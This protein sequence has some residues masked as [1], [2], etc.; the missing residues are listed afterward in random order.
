MFMLLAPIASWR[1]A[2]ALFCVCLSAAA[3]TGLRGG[4]RQLPVVEGQDIKFTRLSV[5]GESLQSKVASITQDGYGFLWFGTDDG[6]YRYDGYNLKPYRRERDNP[7]SLSDD[8][9]TALYRDRAGILWVGTGYGGLNRLDPASDTF[10]HYRHDPANRASLSDN[11]VRCIL[12]DS[13]GTLW[14][15]TNLGLDRLDPASGT[16]VHHIHNPKDPGS[17]SN[18]LV[19]HL[20]EDHS[21]NLWVG[22]VG[23]GVNRLDRRT[24]RFSRFQDPNNPRS[25]GDDRD[26]ALSRIREDRSGVLWTGFALATLDPKS[27]ALTEYA[28]RSKEPGGE[29][30]PD[31]RAILEDH[32]GILWLGTSRSL[33]ALDRERK[34]FVRYTAKPANP[35]SLHNSDIATLFEDAEGN[36]WVGTRTGVSWFNRKTVFV[37]RQHEPGTTQSLA[38]N[39]IRAVYADTHGALWVGTPRGLQQ[40]DLKTGRFTLYEHDSHD[41]YSLSNNYVTVIREDRAGILWVGTGGGGLNRFDRETGRFF[42]YRYEA[43][44]PAGLSSDGVMSLLEDRGGTLWVGTAAGVDRWDRRTGRF[45]IYHHNPEDPHSLSDD[46]VRTIFE[47]RDGVLWMGSNN[48]GLNRFDRASQQFIAYRHNPQDPASLSHD[49]VNAIWEDS[50]GTLWIATQGG[51]NQMDRIRGT[52]TTFT[53][54]EGL[55]D[56]A[57]QAILEDNQG[58]LWLATDNGLSEFHPKTRSFRNYSESHGLPANSLSR[59]G[60]EG[61]CRTPG[62]ELWIGSMNGL[63]SF[64]P[65]RLSANAY[66]P[67]VV[68]TDL[69]LF[70]TP[71][72]PSEH[73]PLR[74]PIWAL[75]SLTLDHKQSIFTLEFSALS[76]AAPERNRYR[77]RLEGLETGWNEVDSRR[78]LA[79][80]TNLPA[81]KYV[82]R[83]QG[84][85]D[86]LRWNEAGARLA[87]TVLPPWWQTWWFTT[88]LGFSAAGLILAA[89]LLRVRSLHLAAARLEFEVEERTRELASSKHS[90]EVARE[91]AESASRAKSTFLSH[92]S[93]ELRTPL[94]AILGF[95]ALVRADTTLSEQHKKDMDIV[96]SSGRQLLRLIDDVLDMAKIEAGSSVVENTC[97]DLHSLLHNIVGMMRERAYAKNLDLLVDIS[98]AAPRFVRS[99]AGKLQQVMINLIGNAVKYTD[100]GSVVVILD[101]KREAPEQ[102]ADR[103]LVLSFDV[104]DT[105]IGIAPEDQAHIFDP[106]IQAGSARTRKGTGLGLS[107]CREFVRLLGGSLSVDSTSGRGSRFHVEL[108]A[109]KAEASEVAAEKAEGDQVM[110]LEPGE[111]DYRIL[112]VEDQKENRLLLERLLRGAGLQ[113][114]TAED[115]VRA[116]ECFASWRPHF[117]WMDLRLALIGGLEA[118]RRIREM[119]GG[120][121]VK[122]VAV[123]ASA[124]AS[125]RDEV[126]AAGLDDFLRKPYRPR[127]IFECMSR[128]LGVRYVYSPAVSAA[129]REPAFRLRPEDLA[130]IPLELR[131]ELEDAIVSL[132]RER[133]ALVIQQIS[134]QNAGIGESL[135]RLS[136]SLAFTTIFQ[137]LEASK[138][139]AQGTE[140]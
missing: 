105:G 53:R 42:A 8:S 41:P 66:V 65:E 6:L 128:H 121:A 95:S 13:G 77:Y 31:V 81:R 72:R 18:N 19:V 12:Q 99:D 26:E 25:P 36:V 22:T 103:D 16:F 127:E 129:A 48:G 96:E 123:T 37:N 91:A 20:L 60:A 50:F 74:R 110:G 15:G 49:K 82:F 2:A 93:H 68:I 90:A 106:F 92:M 89:Y 58:T 70:N 101:A 59:S 24:G 14:V 84:S 5:A 137:S 28:F 3:Q 40:L 43:N 114:R 139:K 46:F 133:I 4:L 45:T 108:P 113:V 94:N 9:V 102:H 63:T 62:G 29:Q 56:D 57:V 118:S 125:Q 134:E 47:D 33:L 17:L 87:I 104:E 97:F 27:G 38:H 51:L 138:P 107:I 21:G 136:N 10:T 35:N 39:T 78:H 98:P 61:S 85:N 86:D 83:V 54:K 7:N 73:S 111:P 32:N 79:T 115:G 117:I 124:F 69:L 52:F 135:A 80:Y 130:A 23:G 116:I 120:R 131:Q 100:Q 122:I 76:Y 140:A 34:Q 11:S 109:E 88:A 64:Y 75:D 126:L 55:P 112:I 71:V 132:N 30:V 119:E 1:A 44:N 67:P